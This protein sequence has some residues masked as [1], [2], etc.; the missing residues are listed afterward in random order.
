MRDTAG[1]RLTSCLDLVQGGDPG[2]ER[3]DYRDRLPTLHPVHKAGS[4]MYT[5]LHRTFHRKDRSALGPW[6]R[7]GS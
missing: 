5:G 2:L 3:L 1:A 6:P 4:R 7:K